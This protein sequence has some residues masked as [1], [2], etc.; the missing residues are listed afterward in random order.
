MKK[1]ILGIALFLAL[2]PKGAS[3][4]AIGQ[5]KELIDKLGKAYAT[6]NRLIGQNTPLESAQPLE[7]LTENYRGQLGYLKVLFDHKLSRELADQELAFITDK[8]LLQKHILNLYDQQIPHCSKNYTVSIDQREARFLIQRIVSIYNIATTNLEALHEVEWLLPNAK[9][10]EWYRRFQQ[11]KDSVYP[12]RRKLVV[13][14]VF[15]VE[16]SQSASFLSFYVLG[17]EEVASDKGTSSIP[18]AA[19]YL[20]KDNGNGLFIKDLQ[21]SSNPALVAKIETMAQSTN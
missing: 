9:F 12:S 2:L 1:H 18:Y 10:H 14:S 3:A 20:V 5:E 21:E 11:D 17:V 16:P 6:N 4:Q 7:L 13:T 8:T 15:P 19:K